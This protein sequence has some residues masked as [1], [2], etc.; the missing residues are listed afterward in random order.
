M[1]GSHCVFGVAVKA[2]STRYLG[3]VNSVQMQGNSKAYADITII[4]LIL[5]AV[6][7]YII[8]GERKSEPTASPI[9]YLGLVSAL[10]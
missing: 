9:D 8:T 7:V 4:I 10:T 1:R 3:A 6:R 2:K 5:M